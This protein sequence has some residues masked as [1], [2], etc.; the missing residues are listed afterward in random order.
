MSESP[1]K[2]EPLL[3]SL[4]LLQHVLPHHLLS[5]LMFYATRM[6]LGKA[7]PWLLQRFVNQYNIDL[8]CAAQPDLSAYQNFNQFFTRALTPEARPLAATAVV[9]PVDGTISELGKIHS[10]TL[11]QAKNHQ[12]TLTELLGGFSPVARLFEDGNYCTLYLSPRDYHRI[13]A[14]LAGKPIDVIYVPGRLFSVSPRTARNI[15]RL[16]ARN[17]RVVVLFKTVLGPMALVMVGAIFV[18]SVDLAWDEGVMPNAW[19]K[20]QRWQVPDTTPHY[21]KGAEVGRFNMGS[22]VI[23]L[24]GKQ[25]IAWLPE[26][27]AGQRMLMGQGLGNRI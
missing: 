12:F 22:T 20:P 16:F 27:S 4:T 23:L 10:E 7:M 24:F 26:L 2:L 5:K 21:D 8:S 18:G 9:S 6:P 25:Q 15:P 1:S 17:E 11:I 3:N 19:R 13:H 14:P